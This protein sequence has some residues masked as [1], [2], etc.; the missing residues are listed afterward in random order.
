MDEATIARVFM[1]LII[2]FYY[3]ILTHLPHCDC[4][5][6]TL[7]ECLL[8]TNVARVARS[9]I[10]TNLSVIKINNKRAQF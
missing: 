2:N 1:S 4:E 7:K 5:N 8:A 6:A 10:Q 9:F 3:Y